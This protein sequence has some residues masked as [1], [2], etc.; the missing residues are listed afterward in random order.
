[1]NPDPSRRHHAF[2][3][4]K[5]MRAAATV[6]LKVRTGRAVLVVLRGTRRT[7]EIVSRLEIG[8]DDPWIPESLHPYHRELGDRWPAAEQD[9]RRGC[10]AARAASK[11]AIQGFVGELRAHGLEPRS[12]ALLT[13]ADD[14]TET[15]GA[16]ARAHAHESQLY[17]SAVDAALDACGLRIT[18]FAE[19]RLRAVAAIRLDRSASQIDGALKAFSYVVGTPWAAPEKHAALAAWLVLSR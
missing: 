10:E 1:L 3:E 18:R 16:H 4:D 13:P 14:H 6:G 17:R 9:R 2:A 15:G 8:L 19:T 11:R 7:P 5:G 12:A